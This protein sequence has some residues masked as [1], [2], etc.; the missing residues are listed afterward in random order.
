MA[1]SASADPHLTLRRI[2][3]QH[4]L[5]EALR[6]RRGEPAPA[7]RL[8]QD[9]GVTTRTVERDIERLRHSGIPISV[10]R[11]P[12]G[13]YAFDAR[14]KIDP[15]ALDPGEVAALVVS[16]VALGP[17]ATES[18]Q[19]GMRKLLAALAIDS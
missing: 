14:S 8:A 2:E 1:F 5:I 12:G 6:A 19:T 11:G 17:T 18:A 10:R 7:T 15:I 9:L 16:L 13:G 3:R 4:A